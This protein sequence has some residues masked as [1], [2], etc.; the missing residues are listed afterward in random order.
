MSMSAGS[1]QL[2]DEAEELL[3]PRER[4]LLRIARVLLGGALANGAAL[5]LLLLLAFLGGLR[6]LPGYFG[7]AQ[8]IL[9]RG[10][11]LAPDTA[12]AVVLLLLLANGG[13]LLVLM[14]G[15][16]AREFWALPGLGLLLLVNLA[17]LLAA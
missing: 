4:A 16:L 11:A 8:G 15:V 9:A 1:V 6:L 10:V 17:G 7:T 5:A 2:I 14:T 12:M 3:E 13:L